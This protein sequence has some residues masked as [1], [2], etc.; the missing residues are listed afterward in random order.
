[1][2]LLLSFYGDDFT[3]S[4]DVMEALALHGVKTAL[5]TRLPSQIE[6]SSFDDYQAIGLAGTSRSQSPEWMAL[7]LPQVFRWMKSLEAKF[8]HYKICST[9][10]SSPESGSI[11]CAIEIALGC[12]DQNEVPMIVGVPQLKRFTFAGTLFAAYQDHVYRIDRHPVMSRHPVT[13]MH[14]ADLRLHLKKQTDQAVD[15]IDVWD[16]P[17]QLRAGQALL[18]RSLPFVVG[19]SGV[20]YA[21]VKALIAA[22]KIDG[23]ADFEPLTKVDR[24]IVMSG[25]VSATTERQIQYALA[26]GFKGI[27]IDVLELA[28]KSHSMSI[29]KYIDEAMDH[30]NLGQ[31]VLVYSALGPATDQS[32]K[33]KD[34]RQARQSIGEG[35]GQ[36]LRDLIQQSGVRRAAIAGGDSSGHALTNL[37][38]Y[39]LTTRLPLRASPGSPLCLAHSSN[40]HFHNF[41]IAMKGGQV[42]SDDYFVM[43]RDGLQ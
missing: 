7:N 26:H 13:P 40:P 27:A 22:G 43:L 29:K 37:D 41:E 16:E 34:S 33:L 30:L 38:I 36:I 18:Q 32:E 14:E 21:L 4:T 12:F 42:G 11:G 39:A 3:G 20:E 5:F 25:S 28:G 2:S 23:H 8:C 35:L 10:D 9:F 6:L 31:S 1:M 19:S 24:M 17:S 15:L